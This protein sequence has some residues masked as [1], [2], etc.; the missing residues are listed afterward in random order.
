M[1]DQTKYAFCSPEWVA[2][3][4]EYLKTAAQNA[5]LSGIDY[6]FNE[7]F[8]NAPAELNPDEQG[9]VGWYLR[10]ANGQVEAKP[11]IVADADVT[12]QADYAGILPLARAVFTDNPEGAA[13][14]QKTIEKM[15]QE[16]K[17]QRTGSDE[18][19]EMPWAGELHD[20]LARRTL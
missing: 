18:Q 14:A 17:F 11:G 4:D 2:I 15:V 19:P 6:T 16:G 13:E 10:V 3:A 1:N 8:T 20:V 12:I 7:V 9:R 5:D